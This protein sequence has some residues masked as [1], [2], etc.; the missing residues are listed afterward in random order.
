MSIDSI[1]HGGAKLP[2]AV[3][4]LFFNPIDILS[5]AWGFLLGLIRIRTLAS[6]SLWCGFRGRGSIMCINII[7]RMGAI[8]SDSVPFECG[9]RLTCLEG[10]EVMKMGRF[11]ENE[12]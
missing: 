12:L 4:L 2:H 10:G 3:F 9:R 8:R 11:A 1:F 7:F 6:F 5:G